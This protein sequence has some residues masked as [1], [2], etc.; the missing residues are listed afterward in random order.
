MGVNGSRR[1]YSSWTKRNIRA[2]CHATVGADCHATVWSCRAD[3]PATVWSCFFGLYDVADRRHALGRPASTT[4]SI[5][6]ASR[7]DT[8]RRY[9]MNN[10]ETQY[11]ETSEKNRKCGCE[12]I[13]DRRK[14]AIP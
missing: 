3:C 7:T 11:T 14:K 4:G 1:P 6:A 13:K 5:D 12:I 9:T 8:T 2:D 10:R